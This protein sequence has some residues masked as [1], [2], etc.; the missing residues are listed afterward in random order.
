MYPEATR[1]L[2]NLHTLREGLDAWPIDFMSRRCMCNMACPPDKGAYNK[3]VFLISKPQ[4]MVI[5]PV[6]QSRVCI[7]KLF[8]LFLNHNILT[9]SWQL[10][11]SIVQE[12]K[13]GDIA[14]M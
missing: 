14:V 3:T 1:E 7:F 4:Y 8:F 12:I 6:L 10:S 11:K 5:W 9:C 13:F 2:G